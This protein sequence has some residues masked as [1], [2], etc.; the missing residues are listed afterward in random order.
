MKLTNIKQSI[1]LLLTTTIFT[2]VSAQQPVKM[3]FDQRTY[4]FGNINEENGPVTHEFQFTNVSNDT[5]RITSVKASCGCTTPGWSKE[6]VLPGEKGFVQARYNP[7]NRPGAFK[8][9]LTVKSNA[10]PAILFIEG[11]VIP[12]PTTPAEDYPAL[13]GN[14]RLKNKTLNLGKIASQTPVTKS[15]D[16][17]NDSDERISFLENTVAPEHLTVSF[18]PRVLGPKQKGKLLITFNPAM[19][20]DL[21]Y[22]IDQLMLI[23]DDAAM[24]NK[25][26]NVMVTV[27][28]YFPPMTD[29]QY[30]RKPHILINE[31]V[32]DFGKVNLGEIVNGNFTIINNGADVLNL[33]QVKSN[34]N[35]AVAKP[36]QAYIN[37]GDST[38]LNVTFNTTGRKGTQHKTITVYSNDP[39]KSVVML[40]IKASVKDAA[41]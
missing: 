1:C 15:F 34:C 24:T 40:T 11:N 37:P 35:C 30:S 25:K 20:T 28:E 33:R 41:N 38:N 18:D 4:K 9:S 22:S 6:A 23:T 3:R 26:L 17:Y 32:Y 19:K 31:P 13:L 8:K 14:L 29:Q 12:K 2:A 36:D 27:E 7:R 21:G 39:R 5:I 16:L 10:G